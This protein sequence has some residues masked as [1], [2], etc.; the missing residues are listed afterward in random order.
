MQ[1]LIE[2]TQRHQVNASDRLLTLLKQQ[3]IL[4]GGL[5]IIVFA[6]VFSTSYLIIR[7]LR[8]S[9][10]HIRALQPIPL[11]GSNEFR[12]LA[13]T[14][15]IMFEENKQSREKLSYDAT[16]D[17]LTGLYNR[18]AYE[19]LCQSVDKQTVTLL[20]VDVDKFKEI[21]DTYGHEIGDKVL[22]NVAWCPTSAPMIACAESAVTN[23]P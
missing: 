13:K 18:S 8:K 6:I 11:E 4:I 14:Y 9:I 1:Q 3:Q 21:N 5:L 15:N 10:S 12:F 16:H 20:L 7:P 23:S 19:A 22:K 2:E 17:I